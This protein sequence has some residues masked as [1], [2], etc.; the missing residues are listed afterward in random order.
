[1]QKLRLTQASRGSNFDMF[2]L[3]L[4]VIVI[5]KYI[6]AQGAAT[7]LKCCLTPNE[8]LLRYIMIRKGYIR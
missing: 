4:S 5:S 3:P 1:M 2:K 8:Q 7:T 6:N